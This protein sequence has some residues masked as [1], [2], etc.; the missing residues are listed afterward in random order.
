M[1][2]ALLYLIDILDI[3]PVPTGYANIATHIQVLRET[4]IDMGLLESDACGL[5]TEILRKHQLLGS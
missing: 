3:I 2:A 5:R 1:L 4:L